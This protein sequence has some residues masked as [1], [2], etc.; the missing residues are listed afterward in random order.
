MADTKL[1]IVNQALTAAGE[2]PLT[3]LTPG[4][5][6][7]NAAIENYDAFVEEELENGGWKFAAKIGN[8]SLLTATSDLPLK[9]RWQLPA[10]VLKVMSVL[11]KGQDL[12]GEF[13]QI[14]GNV[15]R[16][17]YNTDIT[18]KHLYWPAESLWPARFKSIVRGRLKALFMGVSERHAEAE[19]T[20]QRTD[21]KSKIAKHTEAGQ[22]RNR[23][24]GDGT[25]V[26][27]RMG[28]RRRRY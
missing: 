25:L 5:V 3:T 24:L 19:A 6:M 11:Y 23:P 20:E 28:R 26:D 4:T 16:T 15:V 14:E 18:V 17:A 27:A 1:S 12:D 10:G 7:A 22:Q 2:D 8:P 21:M 13:Y 9:Y